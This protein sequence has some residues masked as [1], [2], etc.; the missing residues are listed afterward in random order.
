MRETKSTQRNEIKIP[1]LK[2]SVIKKALT[3]LLEQHFFY[4]FAIKFNRI[5]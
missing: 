3:S 2:D 1:K 5:K 4:F